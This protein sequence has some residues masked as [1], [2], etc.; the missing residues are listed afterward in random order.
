MKDHKVSYLIR[1]SPE[2]AAQRSLDLRDGTKLSALKTELEKL[3]IEVLHLR[4]IG[5]LVVT[6]PTTVWMKAMDEIIGPDSDFDVELNR[7]V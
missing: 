3:D 6:A 7:M 4:A 5:Q 1:L 2:K